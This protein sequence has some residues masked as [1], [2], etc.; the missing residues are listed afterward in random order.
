MN[1][2]TRRG[3][4][5]PTSA[6][7]YSLENHVH[8]FNSF[9]V[10]LDHLDRIGRLRSLQQ[11][12]STG[13][14]FQQGGRTLV[15]FG[16]NDYLGL[17]GGNAA[18]AGTRGSGAS[19]L[20]C[21]WTDDH[22]ILADAIAR[23][24][25]T[26][27]AVVFPSGYAACSGAVATLARAGDLI[28]SDQLNHASLIDGCRM[29]RADCMVYPHRDCDRVAELL[30]EY[31]SDY[32]TIWIVTDGVFS[33]DGHVAP[34]VRLCKLADQFGATV[35][36]DEAHGTGVLGDTGSGTCEELGVK[37]QVPIRIGT[38]SKSIGCQGGFVAGPQVVIDYL[39]NRCRSLI[40]STSL[41]PSAV[42]AATES[43]ARIETESERR[44]RVRMLA[45]RIRD[46]LGIT[47]QGI[48]NEIPIIPILIGDEHET[49]Q[50]SENLWE[51]GFYV[52]AIRPPTV[53]DGSSRL[54]VSLSAD[55][56]D[57]MV[58]KLIDEMRG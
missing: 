30:S 50:R 34:L 42:I 22:Q 31:Q 13:V 45:A 44:A 17:A 19:A 29:S 53:P 43:I 58:D 55:H 37:H 21:G 48:E 39:V 14:T 32:Q 16:S 12:T 8:D 47:F 26:E 24:E 10:E 36:V 5:R 6:Q 33:M 49:V 57:E 56:T 40:Y 52:P 51:Q 38:L 54:R 46:K 28:L 4:L 27:S 3:S 11:R 41:A 35:L 25:S 15:N 7:A 2:V 18:L 9:A 1:A 20:V 23:L